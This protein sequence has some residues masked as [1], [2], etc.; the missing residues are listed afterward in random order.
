M[1]MRLEPG[2]E[3]VGLFSYIYH[4]YATAMA[5]A[6]VQGQG[7]F[8][9]TCA[10]FKWFKTSIDASHIWS[11]QIVRLSLPREAMHSNG[12]QAGALNS[13]VGMHFMYKNEHFTKTGSGQT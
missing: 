8:K 6:L 4:E 13:R 2:F 1:M 9:L 11:C 10:A 5:A 12:R 7:I 3:G